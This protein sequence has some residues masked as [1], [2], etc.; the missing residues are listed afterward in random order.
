MSEGDQFV[1]TFRRLSLRGSRALAAGAPRTEDNGEERARHAPTPIVNPFDRRPSQSNPAQ[2]SPAKSDVTMEDVSGDFG[3]IMNAPALPKPPRYKGSSMQERREFL[4]AYETYFSALSAFQT[5]H[6]RPFVQPV[7]SCI[8]QG[9]K[10]I[11]AKFT[12]AKN[13]QDVT[14]DEWVN[15]FLQAKRTSFEDYAA[16]D[17]AMQKLM[18]DTK[19]A[20]AES[21][22]NRLLSNM[23]KILKEHNMVDVMFERE[24]KKLVKYLVAALAPLN[25]RDDRFESRVMMPDTI[26]DNEKGANIS[27]KL[28][29]AVEDAKNRG[30]HGHALDML[31]RSLNTHEAEFCV[32]FGRHPPV[33]VEPMRVKIPPDTTPV[34]LSA[35]R[36]APMQQA[37]M[38][39]HIAELEELGLVYRNYT[40]RWASAPRIVPKASPADFRMCID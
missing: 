9:T 24:Q 32:V 3:T 27:E 19:L 15:Y 29:V 36:Y 26:A 7:G 10:E 39:A 35:R 2:T 8:E 28:Q 31:E 30:L 33:K 21:R 20:E 16:L 1:E 34:R 12:F 25:Q 40:S 13:W 22:V 5:A 23:Y 38:D 17:S 14:E 6:N 11:I 4:R 18:M 37:F